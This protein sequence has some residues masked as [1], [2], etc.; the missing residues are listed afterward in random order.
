MRQA[1][2][3]V[4]VVLPEAVRSVA[5]Y[6]LAIGKS[7]HDMRACA[8]KGT[9]PAVVLAC[10]RAV[11]GC[12][13]DAVPGAVAVELVHGFSLLHD[14]IMDGDRMR[15]H[16]PAAWVR[17]GVPAALL[18][19][20][21]LLAQAVRVLERTGSQRAVSVL[22]DGLDDLMH[23]QA[24]D[25]AFERREW[26]TREEYL[27]M[28][29]AKTGALMGAACALG[30]V[31]AGAPEATV[32][33]L[34]Q[35]G[36]RAGTAFQCVDDVLGL[37]G[38]PQQTGKPAGGDVVRGKKTY[39]LVAVLGDATPAARRIHALLQRPGAWPPHRVAVLVGAV[40]EAGGRA[41]ALREAAEQLRCALHCLD[42]AELAQ[43]AKAE[44]AALAQTMVR[45]RR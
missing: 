5:E 19:G 18:A 43:E 31:L 2:A 6:H 4:V 21:A 41:A 42:Q 3:E 1:L 35:F 14:D 27:A 15:R 24:M 32:R 26:V 29:Q 22:A 45:R 9:R 44:L 8:G 33:T 13:M 34:E 37:W 12:E 30:A 28:A 16:R 10:A 11:G 20:D 7:A 25:L 23:G 39:P 40:E 38:D 36:R 17:F